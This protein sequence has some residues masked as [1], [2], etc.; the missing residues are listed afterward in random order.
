MTAAESKLQK[1]LNNITTIYDEL[2][3]TLFDKMANDVN[4][5]INDL[6]YWSQKVIDKMWYRCAYIN[7]P[8][9]NWHCNRYPQ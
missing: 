8:Y 3:T 1:L 4:V 7:A 6:N 2:N 5:L 9:W